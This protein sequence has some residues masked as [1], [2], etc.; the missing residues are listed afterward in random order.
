MKKK[1]E[2]LQVTDNYR[3]NKE[4]FELTLQSEDLLPDIF[5]GQFAELR[6]DRTADTLLRRPISFYDVDRDHHK[7]RLLIQEVGA[8]TRQLGVLSPGDTLNMIYPLGHPFTMVEGKEFLLAAGGVG[9]APMLL[10]GKVLN[11]LE[12]GLFFCLVSVLKRRY[13]I[14]PGLKISE[15]F[16]LPQRM[17]AWERKA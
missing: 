13:L 11:K 3:L 14:F 2:D 12:K 9:I 6:I 8:G 10:L 15:K 17:G 4:Y 5:P 1:I 16:I 7:I